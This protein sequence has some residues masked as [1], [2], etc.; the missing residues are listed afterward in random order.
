MPPSGRIEG[1]FGWGFSIGQRPR[2]TH[3][4]TPR[5]AVTG[6]PCSLPN[7]PSS[8]DPPSGR[9][10]GPRA[11]IGISSQRSRAIP[12]RVSRVVP[13]PPS[14]RIEGPRAVI[15][16]SSQRSRAIPSRISR[17]V[18]IP[19]SERIEGPGAAIGISS[20]RSRAIPSRISRVVP[21][22]HR[23]VSMD[24]FFGLDLV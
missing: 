8:P 5:I 7:I 14:E 4:R 16:I 6:R 23:D 11:V 1:L 21:I 3:P 17:V 22:P 2:A 15:G 20:Q 9:I 12:S 19:P 24:L 10:E 18:P 13:I